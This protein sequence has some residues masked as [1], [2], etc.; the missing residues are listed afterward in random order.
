MFGALC[1]RL[2]FVQQGGGDDRA[3]GAA[4]LQDIGIIV[5]GQQG[6]ERDGNDPGIKRAKEGNGPFAP[7]FGQ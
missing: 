2:E 6:I 7:V 4:M 5:D 1:R 3:T